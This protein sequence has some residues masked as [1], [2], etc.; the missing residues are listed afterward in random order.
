M[1]CDKYSGYAHIKCVVNKILDNKWAPD[2][3][4]L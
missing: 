3:R 2:A 1:N 4:G